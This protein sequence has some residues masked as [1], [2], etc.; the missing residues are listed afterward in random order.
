MKLHLGV[1]DVAYS[2]SYAPAKRLSQSPPRSNSTGDVAEILEAR[3]GVMAKF[4]EL[5]GQEIADDV[6]EVLQDKLEALLLGAP[7]SE[8]LLP[9]GSLSKI[10]ERFRK[11]L[12]D[13]ELDGQVAGVPTQASLR[14]V[15]H[16]LLHP[17][18]RRSPRPSFI[19]SGQYQDSMRAWVEE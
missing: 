13:K 14:G 17:Y 6:A 5:H 15:S 3:Y 7:V 8:E 16:R 18:A 11:M 1:L 4:Y 19:D 9:E 10:E 12:D 2:S